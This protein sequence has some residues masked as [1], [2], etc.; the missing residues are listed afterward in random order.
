MYSFNASVGFAACAALLVSLTGCTVTTEPGPGPGPG[1]SDLGTLTVFT[2][3]EGSTHPSECDYAGATDIELAVY[4]GADH[5][6][7]VTAPCYDF[8]IS[9]DVEEGTYSADVTLIDQYSQP[10]STTLALDDLRVVPGTELQ[11]DVDFPSTSLIP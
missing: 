7:T 8:S 3:I 11:V 9:V 6:A 2:S 10:V 5:V 4:E 1:P